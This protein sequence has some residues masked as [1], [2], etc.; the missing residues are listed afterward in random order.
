MQKKKIEHTVE[1]QLNF[2]KFGNKRKYR[3]PKKRV[4]KIVDCSTW[5]ENHLQNQWIYK[6]YKCY[7]I[8]IT[9]HTKGLF[10][11]TCSGAMVGKY[12]TLSEAKME[13]LKFCDNILK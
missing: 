4:A 12:L 6:D 11:A 13:S 7:Y 8:V 10:T 1:Y 2:D 9:E 3:L 5:L